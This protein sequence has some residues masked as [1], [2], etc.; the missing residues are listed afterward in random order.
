MERVVR[1]NASDLHEEVNLIDNLTTHKVG[2]CDAVDLGLHVGATPPIL[3]NV[4]IRTH[5]AMAKQLA[6][7][8]MLQAGV[9][10]GVL[11]LDRF[12][13]GEDAATLMTGNQ[14]GVLYIQCASNDAHCNALR[15][16]PCL[17]L[18]CVGW[19]DRINQ[20]AISSPGMDDDA[21]MVERGEECLDGHLPPL[22]V[23]F[24]QHWQVTIAA[25]HVRGIGGHGMR[26]RGSGEG[27][28][29][30]DSRHSSNR[31]SDSGGINGS[32]GS[33]I[34]RKAHNLMD[35][36]TMGLEAPVSGQEL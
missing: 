18:H 32:L 26:S 24:Q 36:D 8:L 3:N 1:V 25:K 5:H 17:K 33:M 4:L 30:S 16:F 19:M 27:G 35:G 34:C 6:P 10:V 11:G 14:V 20:V 9:V 15:A 13:E 29:R 2:W 22:I 28:R 7:G 31:C 21:D 12:L 23:V